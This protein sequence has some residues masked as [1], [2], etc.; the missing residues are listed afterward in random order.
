M[1]T[2]FE[3]TPS[4]D[5]GCGLAV[6]AA[7]RM[8]QREFHE[9]R[10]GDGAIFQLERECSVESGMSAYVHIGYYKVNEAVMARIVGDVFGLI[11]KPGAFMLGTHGTPVSLFRAAKEGFPCG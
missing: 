1:G 4:A 5:T 9:S 6:V 8:I 7:L 11:P 2:R 10:E 3:I